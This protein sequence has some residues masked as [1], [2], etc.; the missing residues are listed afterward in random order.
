MEGE[1]KNEC[2]P[3]IVSN[4]SVCSILNLNRI[5]KKNPKVGFVHVVFVGLKMP[6]TF[7]IFPRK[8]TAHF[9]F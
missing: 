3:Y 2:H 7:S 4:L 1:K 5:K 9:S 8:I 6:L